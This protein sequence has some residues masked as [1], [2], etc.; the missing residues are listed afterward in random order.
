MPD[1]LFIE[2]RGQGKYEGKNLGADFAGT[3]TSFPSAGSFA[4]AAQ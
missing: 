1:N 3:V 2:R 4:D